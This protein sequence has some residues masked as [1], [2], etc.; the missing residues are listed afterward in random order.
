MAEAELSK[1][2]TAK[3]FS[4]L[5]ARR[6][7]R[8]IIKLLPIQKRKFEKTAV[9][10]ILFVQLYGIGDYLMSTPA[11]S[12]IANEFPKAEKIIFCKSAPGELAALNPHIGKVI[13]KKTELASV[14]EIDLGISLN[15][16]IDGTLTTLG[17]KPKYIIGFLKG[18]TVEAN[19]KIK[20]TRASDEKPWIENYLL[21]AEALDAKSAGTNYALSVKRAQSSKVDSIIKA[22]GLK[23]FV[24]INPNTRQ[25]AEGKNWGNKNYA[26]LGSLLIENGFKVVFCGANDEW[27]SKKTIEIMEHT[28]PK[29]KNKVIDLTGKLSLTELAYFLSKAKLFIGNDSGPMHIA[30][31]ADCPTIGIFG[32]TNPKILFPKKKNSAALQVKNREWPSYVRGVIRYT[33]N[34]EYMNKITPEKVMAKSKELLK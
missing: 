7:A 19:F 20:K 14:G 6:A 15:D 10:R 1:Q 2:G 27:N 22:Q 34:Q 26:R 24:V 3:F 23:K 16:S 13:T 9:K 29:N 8:T 17:A 30:L 11:I 21:V 31:A 28:N 12:T 5:V 25:G 32:P 18:K 4:T 33:P